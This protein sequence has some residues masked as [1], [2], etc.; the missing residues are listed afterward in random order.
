MGDASG[1]DD[2]G[3]LARWAEGDAA[4]GREVFQRHF[5]AVLRFFRNKASEE[6]VEDLVQTTFAN[7]LASASAF[8]GDASLRTYL[9]TI[10]RHELYAHWR[11]RS[12]ISKELDIGS[13]SFEDLATSPSGVIVAHQERVLLARALRSIPLDLQVA[14]E[15][16]YWEELSGPELADILDVPEGTV[17]SR[18][19][20]GREL[21][22]ERLEQLA[23]G[24]ATLLNASAEDIDGWASSLKAFMGR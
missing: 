12:K 6:D 19:R 8:R 13:H 2:D 20:R 17:R 9:L 7:C 10:A 4:A 14:L 21:L 1:G 16:H 18:L 15:L 5:E 11:K 24:D 22:A 23:Q 3:L